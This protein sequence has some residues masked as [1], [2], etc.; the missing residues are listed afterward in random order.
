MENGDER[1]NINARVEEEVLRLFRGEDVDNLRVT[2]SHSPWTV[3]FIDMDELC[4]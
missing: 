2:H 4:A 1:A 3:S